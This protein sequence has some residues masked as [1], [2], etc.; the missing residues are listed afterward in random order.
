[1]TRLFKQQVGV[2]PSEYRN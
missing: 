1:F 2:T